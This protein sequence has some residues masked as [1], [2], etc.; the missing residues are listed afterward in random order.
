MRTE[1]LPNYIFGFLVF[2]M[3]GGCESKPDF[4]GSELLPSG[5]DFSVLFDS[6]EV[7]YGYTRLPDSLIG[8]RKELSPSRSGRDRG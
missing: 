8:S 2:L 7:I 4:I 5:D 6:T 3:I 1:F